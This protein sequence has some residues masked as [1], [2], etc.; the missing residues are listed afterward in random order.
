MVETSDD[1]LDKTAE[2][3]NCMPGRDRLAWSDKPG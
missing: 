2:P 1:P 3:E